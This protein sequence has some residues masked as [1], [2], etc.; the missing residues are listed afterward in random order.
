M[1]DKTAIE[2]GTESSLLGPFYQ[3][4]APFFA[5]GDTI[6]A[7]AEGPE[8]LL[9]GHVTDKAGKPLPNASGAGLADR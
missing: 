8:L 9:Y 6:A 7:K 5:L 2:L 4:D 1:H 3:Q